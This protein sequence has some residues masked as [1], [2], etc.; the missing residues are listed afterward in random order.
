M[1]SVDEALA[2]AE[3]LLT[4]LNERREELE[5]LAAAEDVDGEAAVDVIA[6]LAELARQIEAELTRARTM[7]DAPG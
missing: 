7:A 1:S 6:E 2:R 4:Q 5:R 3:E